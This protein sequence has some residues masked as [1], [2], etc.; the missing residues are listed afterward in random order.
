[1]IFH[2]A[3]RELYDNMNSLRFALTVLLIL[4]LMIVN[5]VKHRGDYRA[6]MSIYR[7]NVAQSLD[8]LRSSSENLYDLVE[9]GPGNFYKQ[10]SPL[11]FC[12]DGGGAFLPDHVLAAEGHYIVGWENAEGIHVW[13]NG[14]WTLK[15]PDENPNLRD[16]RPDYT[17]IDWVLVISVVLSFVAILFTFDSISGERERGTL[18]LILSNSVPRSQILIGKFLGAL[19]SIGLPFLMGALINLFLLNATNHISLET[20]DWGQLGVIFL[21]AMVYTSIF[22]ALGL[23]ISA[24]VNQPEISLTILLLIWAVFVVLTPNTLGSIVSGLEPAQ[25]REEYYIRRGEQWEALRE[26][27]EWPSGL[28]KWEVP[29]ARGTEMWAKYIEADAELEERLREERLKTQM[30]Q[31]LFARSV[32]RVSPASIVQFAVESLAGTG[33]SRHLRFLDGVRRYAA[34]YR[35]FVISTDQADP[36]SPHLYF[37]RQGMSEKPVPYSVIPKFDDR[38]EFR[39]SINAAMMDISLLVLFA[40]VLFVGAVLAFVRVDI[41]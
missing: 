21:I 7:K 34:Q 25:T 29:P 2:I 40:V 20:R 8:H 35:E 26:R 9:K 12:A 31:V 28:P 22:I 32:A 27:Y 1:M 24:R 39:E 18:R 5:A 6:E 36:D 13:V 17:Q 37:V 16:I 4:T 38:I 15:F 30:D 23:L 19:L 11:S 14:I 10:P 3:K 33:L 41:T